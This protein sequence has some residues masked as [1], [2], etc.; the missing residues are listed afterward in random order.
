MKKLDVFGV[1]VSV[2]ATYR[3]VELILREAL[4][5]SQSCLVSFVNPHAVSLVKGVPGYLPLLQEMDLVLCDGIGMAV[6]SKVSSG[7]RTE[8]LSFD[9]TSLSPMVFSVCL[10]L[11]IP[12]FLIG[13]KPGVTEHAA[14]V[15]KAKYPSLEVAGFASGYG[16]DVERAKLDILRQGRVA[17]I[18]GLGAPRQEEFLVSL[19]QSGW[20]GVGFTCGGYFDQLGDRDVYYPV[21][22]DRINARFIYRLVKEPRRLWRRYFFEYSDFVV[23]FFRAVLGRLIGGR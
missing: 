19:R 23:A 22:I 17:V 5:K 12:V 11:N 1:P 15:F 7:V 20:C 3:N 10:E 2:G 16:N 8:R 9:A 4:E 13:G 6:G 14:A 21:W 18:A